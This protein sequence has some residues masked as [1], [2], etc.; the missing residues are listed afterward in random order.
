MTLVDKIKRLRKAKGMSLADV[1]ERIGVHREAVARLERPD[2]DPRA[3]T[4]AAIAEALEVPVC[5]LFETSG[6]ERQQKPH[7][8]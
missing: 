2:T 4:L 7:T 1:A 6:H 8:R 3:S 5:K